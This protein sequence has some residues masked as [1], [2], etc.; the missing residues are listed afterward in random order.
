MKKIMTILALL[1]AML[2]V[3]GCVTDKAYGVAKVGYA[4]GKAA[5]E[6]NADLI[7]DETLNQLKK[8]DRAATTYDKTRTKVREALD[9]KPN[10]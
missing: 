2:M 1:A 8:V 9:A 6:A 5:V 10:D 4:G 3:T 7:P